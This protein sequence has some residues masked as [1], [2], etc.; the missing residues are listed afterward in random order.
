MERIP[1]VGVGVSLCELLTECPV[2]EVFRVESVR[3]G[4]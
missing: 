2:S 1:A 4:E 3:D